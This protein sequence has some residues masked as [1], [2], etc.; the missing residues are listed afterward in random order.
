MKQKSNVQ[1]LRHIIQIV[2]LLIV[3]GVVLARSLDEVGISIPLFSGASLHAICP[4]GGVV[5]LY[6]LIATGRFVQK[7]HESSV[8][9]TSLVLILAVLFGPVFCGWVCPF[10]T[11]QEWLARLGKRLFKKRF[12]KIIPKS[13][14]ALLR[15]LRYAV[16]LW[17]VI[18][19]AVSAKLI[20]SDY[21]PYYALF[22]FWTGEVAVTGLIT[23]GV[24]IVLALIVERPF[25]RYA[26]PYGALLGLS[27]FI[28]VFGIKRNANTCISCKACDRA[29][30]MTITVS[31]NETVRNHQCISC[32]KCTSESACPIEHTVDMG[33]GE[34]PHVE[35]KSPAKPLKMTIK[36]RTLAVI[37]LV[38]MLGGIFFTMLTGWWTTESAKVPRRISEGELAGVYDPADIRGAYSFGDI[39]TNFGVPA[40]FM[41][42]S[43]GFDV[44][45]AAEHKTKDVGEAYEA[46]LEGT[47][48]EMGTDS[49]RWLVSLY[50]GY[51]Y[52]QEAT[53]VLPKRG[54]D[55]ML[56]G[57]Q[58]SQEQYDTLIASHSIDL[59]GLNTSE[60]AAE[61]GGS[62]SGTTGV[63]EVTI[64]G[65]DTFSD[66]MDAGVS[67]ALIEQ[68][69]G[70]P[71]PSKNDVVRDVC[72]ANGVEFS[73]F[74]TAL[75]VLLQSQQ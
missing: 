32:M 70:F 11:F 42:E 66:I 39:E 41:A 46:A 26:C 20:F 27:N 12:D 58:I 62:D 74:K 68:A 49:V 13:V 6:E 43:F 44:R 37:V 56:A 9:L 72:E 40:E 14:D 54:L 22:N 57:G 4:F 53:T 18:M 30:P 33:F 34:F 71:I 64:R 3:L 55:L 7:I 67:A 23:L 65:K 48:A 17:V 10:G 16:L 59:D 36:T 38:I 29:C 8:I 73:E 60:A 61:E 31:T 45:V 63:I 28:R 5:T 35:K 51:P 50:L 47:G 24:V 2:F 15:Y 69:L 19:T 52:D 25:C 21:D 1:R 75:G